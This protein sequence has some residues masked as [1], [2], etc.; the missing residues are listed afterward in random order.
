ML[1]FNGYAR[2]LNAGTD[3]YSNCLS[4]ASIPTVAP[5]N[6]VGKL[7]GISIAHNKGNG[8]MAVVLL[9]IGSDPLEGILEPTNENEQKELINC[10]HIAIKLQA[11]SR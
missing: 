7:S 5:L 8:M 10:A 9:I 4:G 2:V 1:R 11:L 3:L 6:L